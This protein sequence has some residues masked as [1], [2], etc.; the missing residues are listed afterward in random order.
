MTAS[1]DD[2]LSSGIGT[3]PTTRWSCSTEGRLAQLELAWE[4]GE[5]LATDDSG[6]VSLFD[7]AGQVRHVS[8]GL[9]NVGPLAFSATG[10]G[11]A[12]A[13]G[14]TRVAVLD[15]N[16]SVVWSLNLYDRI[17]ALAFDPF[18]RHL[19][20]AL[21]NRDVRIYTS[22]RRSIAE[23]EVVRPLKFLTFSASEPVLFGAA[24][25]GLLG[26]FDLA[27]RSLWDVRLFTSCGDL[28]VSGSGSVILLAGFAHGI[29]RFDHAG[30]N[31]GT[32]VVEGTPSR[33]ATNYDGSRIAAATIERQIYALDRSGDLRWAASTPDDVVAMRSDASGKSILIGFA[34]GRMVFV[35]W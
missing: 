2:W 13:T 29:Q 14:E 35:G 26:A 18:G 8:R 12:V 4:S 9:T 17:T 32:F 31:R 7:A 19:A 23:F 20:V 22:T 27:G 24:E 28:A 1:S 16:L 3:P 21:A 15:R 5:V 10:D 34:S 33:I 6:G 11:L 25:D 30:A